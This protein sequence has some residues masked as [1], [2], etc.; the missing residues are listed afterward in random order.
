MR[1]RGSRVRQ[2]QRIVLRWRD[3]WRRQ[4]L[5]HLGLP[6]QVAATPEGVVDVIAELAAQPALLAE[7]R[8]RLQAASPRLWC[9]PAPLRALERW[10][11]TVASRA[12]SG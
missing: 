10:L 2:G 11:E 3:V 9:D 8:G 4:L 6:E 1:R 7:R 12:Q 5:R